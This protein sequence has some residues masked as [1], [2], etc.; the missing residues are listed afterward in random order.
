MGV[1]AYLSYSV[2]KDKEGESLSDGKRERDKEKESKS[3]QQD[4]DSGDIFILL[5]SYIY[6]YLFFPTGLHFLKDALSGKTRILQQT[7]FDR[8]LPK[9]LKPPDTKRDF[10]LCVCIFF[11]FLPWLSFFRYM[12]SASLYKTSFICE[13]NIN[14]HP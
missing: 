10:H 6:I 11:S 1:L 3:R 2:P 14:S 4:F 5:Y 8:K 13:V 12:F 9:T 7:E